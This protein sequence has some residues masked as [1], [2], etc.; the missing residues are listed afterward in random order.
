[1]NKISTMMCFKSSI[2]TTMV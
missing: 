1:M 2:Y